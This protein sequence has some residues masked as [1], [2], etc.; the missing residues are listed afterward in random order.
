MEC[1]KYEMK[2][3]G[4]HVSFNIIW[5]SSKNGRLVLLIYNLKKVRTFKVYGHDEKIVT[6]ENT[7]PGRVR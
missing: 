7:M 6:S 3:F 5:I 1:L 4:V 2:R